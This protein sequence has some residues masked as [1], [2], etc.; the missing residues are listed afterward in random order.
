[1]TNLIIFVVGILVG[2]ILTKANFKITIHH[3]YE[4]IRKDLDLKKLQEEMLKENPKEDEEF[5]KFY[6]TMSE[7][8]E[9]MTGSDR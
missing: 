5:E 3:K 4:D 1:M 2:T 8:G 7:I 9:I 6:D